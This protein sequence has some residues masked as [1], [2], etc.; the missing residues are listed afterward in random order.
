MNLDAL[1]NELLLMIAKSLDCQSSLNAFARINHHFHDLFNSFLYAYN[2]QHHGGDALHWAA[3]HGQLETAQKSLR[4]GAQIESQATKKNR[5]TGVP[6][7]PLYEAALQGH[8][9]MVAFLVENGAGIYAPTYCG[10]FDSASTVAVFRNRSSVLR[11]LL[12]H[13]LDPNFD[14]TKH[15]HSLLEIAASGGSHSR[16]GV[17]KVLVEAGADLEA[18]SAHSQTPLQTACKYEPEVVRY[19]I[20]KGANSNV[21]GAGGHTLLQLAAIGGNIKVVEVLLELGFDQNSRDDGG[22]NAL[23]TACYSGRL[24]VAKLLL[25]NGADINSKT[26]SGSTPLILAVKWEATVYEGRQG[27]HGGITAFL[28]ERGAD[29]NEASNAGTAPLHLAVASK[30]GLCKLLLQ[31]GALPESKRETGITPLHEAARVGTLESVGE[32][33]EAGAS[34]QAQDGDRNTPLHFAARRYSP[35]LVKMLIQAGADRVAKNRHGKV[36]AHIA[37]EGIIGR[38][39]EK[40]AKL[41]KVLDLLED[42]PSVQSS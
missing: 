7:R 27:E 31:H 11:A 41:R 25:E 32:L 36:P 34:V 1:P 33:L 23:Q 18:L 21:R 3:T 42:R 22:H 19:L 35:E 20:E 40:R 30:R 4:Q 14:A 5:A 12:D 6:H 28:L 2:V 26:N 37:M 16:L 13:G 8:A 9:K 15:G 38:S 39:T 17:T 24:E 29:P 10:G